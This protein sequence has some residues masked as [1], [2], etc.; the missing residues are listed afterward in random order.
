MPGC[1]DI[2][3][4]PREYFLALTKFPL[5]PPARQGRDPVAGNGFDGN[6]VQTQLSASIIRKRR[7][8]GNGSV[9]GAP[10]VSFTNADSMAR[11][12]I[13]LGSHS[14]CARIVSLAR[15]SQCWAHPA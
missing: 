7:P 3:R 15:P 2:R 13:G 5:T 8:F 11:P 9:V 1:H 12:V 10:I 4:R 6:G 14:A